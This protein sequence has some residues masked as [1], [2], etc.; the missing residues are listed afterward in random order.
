MSI[1]IQNA[2]TAWSSDHTLL[3]ISLTDKP[4]EVFGDI[5]HCNREKL[6][7]ITRSLVK[8]AMVHLVMEIHAAS[9]KNQTG[10]QGW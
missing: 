3:G 10:L 1:K 6:E 7:T 9:K 8:Q 5:V 4:A 2:H